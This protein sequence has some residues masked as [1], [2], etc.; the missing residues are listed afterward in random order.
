M[1][2]RK[3]FIKGSTNRTV[4]KQYVHGVTM[5]SRKIIKKSLKNCKN[6]T[7]YQKS[8]RNVFP[9]LNFLYLLRISLWCKSPWSNSENCYT[10]DRFCYFIANK[11]AMGLDKKLSQLI[12]C[13]LPTNKEN[14]ILNIFICICLIIFNRSC[15]LNFYTK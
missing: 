4:T 9:S 1:L 15:G 10:M 7:F 2:L 13:P 11:T 5:I 8:C 3:Q 12:D 6:F 14:S